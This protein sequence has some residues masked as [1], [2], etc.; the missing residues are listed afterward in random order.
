MH[1][2][3]LRARLA[4]GVRANVS[5]QRWPVDRTRLVALTFA[6][7]AVSLT[8]SGTAYARHGDGAA[9]ALGILGGGLAGVAITFSAGPRITRRR[10]LIII[11]V[12]RTSSSTIWSW[13]FGWWRWRTSRV[14]R[15]R[16]RAAGRSSATPQGRVRQSLAASLPASFR[17]DWPS[18][19]A[20]RS[21]SSAKRSP[22]SISNRCTW[23]SCRPRSVVNSRE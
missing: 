6:V 11:P 7:A 21:P 20:T 3:G 8:C 4:I 5:Y 13:W 19:L 14:S 9:V 22:L 1:T 15:G 10:P 17:Q 16:S 12:G 18:R 23:R 2:G